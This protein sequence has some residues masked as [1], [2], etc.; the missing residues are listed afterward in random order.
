MA[1]LYQKIR[2]HTFSG[3]VGQEAAVRLIKAQPKTGVFFPVNLFI[4]EHGCGKT[5][6]AGIMAMAVNCLNLQPDGS[7]CLTCRNC[8][9]VLSGTC[10]D[11][12][13]IDAASNNGVDFVRLF[14]EQAGYH[15]MML[16]KR[17]FI[18][19]EV[20]M[21]STAA[22]NALLKLFENVPEHSMFILCT[23]DPQKI[24]QTVKS[25]CHSYTFGCIS[26]ETIRD[27]LV[28]VS[29]KQGYD[30]EPEAC[31]VIARNACGAMRDAL[32]LLEQVTVTGEHLTAAQVSELLGATDERQLADLLHALLR[33]DEKSLI[34]ASE[35]YA[36]IGKNYST[37]VRELLSFIRDVKVSW[38]GG[39]VFGTSDYREI[40]REFAAYP[41]QAVNELTEMLYDAKKSL[42]DD[43]MQ[44]NFDV[45]MTVIVNRLS[46]LMRPDNRIVMPME[47]AAPAVAESQ[48][49]EEAPEEN[50]PVEPEPA[51]HAA[52]AGCVPEQT[53]SEPAEETVEEAV[54]ELGGPVI[55]ENGDIDFSSYFFFSEGS[56][57]PEGT[58][59]IP[60]DETD[61]ADGEN[62]AVNEGFIMTDE[63]GTPFSEAEEEAEE[64][65]FDYPAFL[66]NCSELTGY[67]RTCAEMLKDVCRKEPLV[68]DFLKKSF[69]GYPSDIGY[70]LVA[71]DNAA[72]GTVSVYLKRYKVEN[73]IMKKTVA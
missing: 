28:D 3:V 66:R 53:V 4:G 41:V 64:D 36:S 39:K 63:N 21:L 71:S 52:P 72:F 7:P 24:P 37:L 15:P 65:D 45:Q 62:E 12:Q 8:Q 11:I 20:H 58:C 2:P 31:A 13:E 60:E 59:V 17:V 23:T 32:V 56:T 48:A 5:T 1:G 30:I 9:A 14:T 26:T 38:W 73:V 50:A 70:T 19:D 68:C 61:Y 69:S 10:G 49:P 55:D 25:R 18:L 35:M 43:P 57:E 29:E 16:K 22:F 40:L 44:S 46:K 67:A 47:Q 34:R 51:E 27:Y 42:K 54:E 33:L 6:V